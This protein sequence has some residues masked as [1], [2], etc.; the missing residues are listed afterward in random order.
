MR[1]KPCRRI[2][3]VPREFFE[4]LHDVGLAPERT[5]EHR[6]EIELV[7]AGVAIALEVVGGCGCGRRD[8]E[9]ERFGLTAIRRQQ[10]PQTVYRLCGFVGCEVEAAPSGAL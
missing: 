4:Q 1:S 2:D 3:P 5:L 6:R 7:D 8:G 9:F 10:L